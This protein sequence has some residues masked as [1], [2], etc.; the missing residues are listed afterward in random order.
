MGALGGPGSAGP[1]AREGRAVGAR[2][3]P[4]CSIAGAEVDGLRDCYNIPG[5][6]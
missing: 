4:C 2:D 6:G 1:M 3:W 5:Q